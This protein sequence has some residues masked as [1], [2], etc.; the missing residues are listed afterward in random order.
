MPGLRVDLPDLLQVEAGRSIAIPI[1]LNRAG[2]DE[3]MSIHFDGVPAGVTIP[4]VMVPAGQDRA[5][6]VA[7]A[8]LDAPAA[9]APVAMSVRAGSHRADARLRVSVR[10]NPAM[11]NRTRGHTLLACGRH[12]EA[13]A[14]FTE[15]IRAGVA[16][17][18]VYN[19]RGLAY[20][21]LNQLDAAIRDYTEAIRLNP[22]D[23]AFRYNRGVAL[24]RRGDDVRALL[25]LDTAIRLQPGHAR[26]YEARARIYRKHGDLAR[27]CADN[28]RASELSGA[29]RPDDRPASPT[30]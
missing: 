21:S 10:A 8:R 13:I 19:N 25:D 16:D 24:A 12:D 20:A 9:T 11:L 1:R 17:A 23:A 6:V 14:A 29:G 7:C 2:H 3:A 4:D 26:A 22:T 28:G 27:S 15:A 30:Q 18:L 5:E